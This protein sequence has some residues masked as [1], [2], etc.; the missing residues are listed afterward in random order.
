MHDIATDA[1]MEMAKAGVVHASLPLSTGGAS[2]PMTITGVSYLGACESLAPAGAGADRKRPGLRLR[3]Y[4][5]RQ[6]LGVTHRIDL[7]WRGTGA[8]PPRVQLSGHLLR[9]LGQ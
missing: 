2:S 1:I 9:I 7:E 6:E 5:G 3:V 4:C 8:S